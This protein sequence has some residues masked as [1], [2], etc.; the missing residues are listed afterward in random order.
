MIRSII[1]I[2]RKNKDYKIVY[3]VIMQILSSRKFDLSLNI[4]DPELI[5]KS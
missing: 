1:D 2:V 4:K 5:I 3:P